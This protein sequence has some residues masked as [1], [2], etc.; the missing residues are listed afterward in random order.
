MAKPSDAEFKLLRPLWRAGRMS[1]REIHESTVGE[2]GWSYSTTRKTLDRMID[3]GLVRTRPVHGLKTYAAAAS[4]LE[5]LARLAN[6]FARNILDLDGP[7]PAATFANS[8][9]VDADE[10]EAL[11]A[12]LAGARKEKTRG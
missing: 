11:E 4:K 1:A 8:K 3:K 9:V 7:L 6:D 5:T 2:T 12:L 10:I